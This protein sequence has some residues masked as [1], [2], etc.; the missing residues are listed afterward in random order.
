V[1]FEVTGPFI[2]AG[3]CHCSRCRRHSGAAVCTQ[4]RV[5]R[6]RFRLT[7]G[8]ELI[9][10]YRPGEGASKAFCKV[11]G[12][13]LFGGTW[14]D[15]TEVSIRLGS[16]DGDPGIR[17]QYHTFVGSRAPWD[18]ITDDLPRHDG[19]LEDAAS[20][21]RFRVG[22]V[23]HV[24]LF[25]PERREAARWYERVLG[26][27]IVPSCEHWAEDPRGPLMISPDGGRTK[28][29]LFRGRPQEGRRTAGFHLVAF[30]VDAAGLI[31]F[32]GRLRSEELSDAGGSRVGAEDLVDH[33]QAY[34]IYFCD[35]Y[36]H[37]LE[38]TTYD[39]EAV[40]ARLEDGP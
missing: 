13:S 23:D 25:V 15:G 12:S 26:C 29:A 30:R 18:E 17:P 39:H 16:I 35:P 2:R 22:S 6:E 1:R 31:E 3:H 7:A 11:C 38:V 40:T 37:R 28:L 20:G 33:G 10:N 5:P 4:G 34:S 36:G 21:L 19:P 9:R 8:A 24:E 32:L 14:P 27:S